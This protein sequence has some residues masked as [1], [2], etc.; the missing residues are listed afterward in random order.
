MPVSPVTA[1]LIAA[2][3]PDRPSERD[4]WVLAHRPQRNAL[5]L[6]RPYAYLIEEEPDPARAIIP[7]ATIFLTNRECPWRCV[8]CDLWRNTLATPTPA[9]A[10]PAQIDFALAE[11]SITGSAQQ[12]SCHPERSAQR[13]VEGPAFS[14]ARA[15][16]LYNAGSFFDPRAIP[17]S[18]HAAIAGRVRSF[19]RV[20]V[21]CHPALVNDAVLGFRDLLGTAQLEVAMGLE[22]AHPAVLEKLNKRIT[23]SQFHAAAEFLRSHNI[24]LRVFIIVQPPFMRADESLHW[25]ER[26]LDFAFDC[27]ATAATLIPTRGGNG[28]MEALAASGDFTPPSLATLEAAV[29]YGLSLRRGRV[30]S[31]L[32]DLPRPI[33]CPHCRAARVERL[34]AINLS[35]APA[36]PIPCAA[37][38]GSA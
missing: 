7:V 31:D 1:D 16:K 4:S 5:D 8:M 17:P 38:G 28:A 30:F 22:N 27:G 2:S 12:K 3:Y 32:W 14:F 33:D 29:G 34:R 10:I 36:P 9:G 13:G 26:S 25:A 19:E 23:L 21:E 20:I 11:L 18:D 15:I 35:Q 37:C 6:F 24:A